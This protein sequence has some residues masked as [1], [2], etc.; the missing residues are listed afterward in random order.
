MAER[1]DFAIAYNVTKSKE[2]NI[3]AKPSIPRLKQF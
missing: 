1:N 2:R 3:E